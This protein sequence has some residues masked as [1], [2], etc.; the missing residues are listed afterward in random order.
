[1]GNQ[2]ETH[3]SQLAERIT[4]RLDQLGMS[5]RELSRRTGL[6]RQTIHNIEKEGST[7][8]KPATF[9][10]LDAALHWDSGTALAFALGKKG[11]PG[12]TKERVL[13]YLSQIAVHTSRMDVTQLELCLIMME[14]NQLGVGNNTTEEFMR[15][16]EEWVAG[17]QKQ[18][19]LL[20]KADHKHAS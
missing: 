6:S 17:W 2:A 12:A 20:K 7:N 19:D 16:I 4:E 13:H 14:E 8:L 15:T 18:I 3:S 1:M 11:D 9:R 5:R 10:A